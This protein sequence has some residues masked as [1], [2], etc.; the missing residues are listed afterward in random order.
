[1]PKLPKGMFKRGRSFYVRRRE[2]GKDRWHH[3]GSDYEDSCR[4]L[5]KLRRQG[6]RTITHLT[7]HK[8]AEEWFRTYVQ[9]AR[10]QYGIKQTAARIERFLEPFLG[11]L[12]LHR[13]S[14]QDLRAYRLWLE[15]KGLA[16][17]TVKHI[18]GDARCLLNWAEDAGYLDRSPFPKRIMPR[19]EERPPD[20]LTDDEL[21]QV[22]RIPGSHGF[23]VRLAVATGMRWGELTRAKS[24]DVE[25]SVLVVHRTKSGKV[26]RIPI[27][28]WFQPEL[29]RHVGT[30]VPFASP[31]HFNAA[32]RRFSG[33]EGFHVHQLRHTFACRWL[34]RG[35]SLPALQQ[36]LGH[37][38]IVTTQRYGRLSDESVRREVEVVLAGTSCS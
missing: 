30:L 8:A 36:L 37:S 23:V 12:F 17:L 28:Q 10:S 11:H 2:G 27:P 29:R 1:M 7:V 38:S 25:H 31:G 26:R 14:P 22:V 6:E 34:E 35:G 16:A 24:S 5:R 18:L 3:L 33:V 21:K 9:N 13:L 32:V 15:E 20:R 4:E 19:I